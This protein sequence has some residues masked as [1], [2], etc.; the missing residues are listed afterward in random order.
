MKSPARRLLQWG[1]AAVSVAGLLIWLS[2]G[3]HRGWTRTSET[4]KTVDEV[5]GIEGVTNRERF[6]PGL[7]FLAAIFAGSIL[8]GGSSLFFRGKTPSQTRA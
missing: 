5:T 2:A 1:A 4:I 8:L 7:D 3:A 6:V